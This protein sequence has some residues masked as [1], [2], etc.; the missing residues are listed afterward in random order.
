[1]VTVCQQA[2]ALL[3]G[4]TRRAV[5]NAPPR[6]LC[7]LLILGGAFYGAVM[8]SYGG[9]G[10]DRWLQV[11]ISASKVP[12]LLLTTFGLALPSFFVLNT[13]LGV[14][15][16]FGAVLRSLIEA[17]AGLTLVLAALA[18]YTAFWYLSFTDYQPAILVNGAMFAIASLAGQ[19][20][21]RRS[22]RPLIARNARHRLLL[23]AWLVLYVFVGIQMAWVL[24]PFVGDPQHA[25]Q[26][27]RAG[28]W[29]N[30]YVIVGQLIWDVIRP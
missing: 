15:G 21:L 30:A 26:F 12:L 6:T 19:W 10:T 3:R 16:D 5:A 9:F 22:Y 28:A 24:R 1:M 7:V 14:R 18:P 11:L 27:F 2:D 20:L 29:G 23:R 13:L 17:Q 4:D 8:G 25:P